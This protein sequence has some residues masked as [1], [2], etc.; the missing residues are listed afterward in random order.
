MT[1]CL[2]HYYPSQSVADLS[3]WVQTAVAELKPGDLLSV[4]DVVVPGSRLRGKK[5]ELQRQAGGYVNAFLQMSGWR[6]ALS[7]NQWEDILRESGFVVEYGGSTAV[8]YTFHDWALQLSP[9]DRIRLRALLV[10][11]PAPV[12]DYLTPQ[13]AGDRIAFYLQ[14]LWIIGRLEM[15]DPKG[16]KNP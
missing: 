9:P 11:A 2:T 12:Q 1:D 13:F 4:R 16:F 15:P 5:A 8:A 14:E 3:G 6:P 7:Q 10:Q